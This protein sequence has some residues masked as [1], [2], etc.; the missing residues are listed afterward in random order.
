MTRVHVDRCIDEHAKENYPQT[1]NPGQVELSF[2]VSF[3]HVPLITLICY[4]SGIPMAT[5]T[6]E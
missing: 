4:I 5:K 2:L 3:A 6:F 1:K